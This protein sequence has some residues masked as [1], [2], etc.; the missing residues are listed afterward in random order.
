MWIQKQKSECIES[1]KN[2]ADAKRGAEMKNGKNYLSSG[3][4]TYP[5]AF[6]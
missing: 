2:E 3:F 6:P 1:E 4:S 5:A